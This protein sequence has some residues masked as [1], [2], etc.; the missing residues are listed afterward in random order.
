MIARTILVAFAFL[1]VNGPAR[2]EL[3]VAE[4]LQK[5]H[6]A[7]SQV[8]WDFFTGGLMTGMTWSNTFLQ[9]KHQKQLF[10]IPDKLAVTGTQADD[11]LERYLKELPDISTIPVGMGFIAAFAYTFP[12]P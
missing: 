6:S 12:C 11:I 5:K 8:Q 10:C 2:A 9:S 3:T 7:S 1:I 4:Y